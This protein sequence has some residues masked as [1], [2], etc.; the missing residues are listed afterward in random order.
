MLISKSKLGLHIVCNFGGQAP[1]RWS[2]LDSKDRKR[3]TLS[4][5]WALAYNDRPGE[6]DNGKWRVGTRVPPEQAGDATSIKI[7]TCDES[8]VAFY[9]GG[10]T[11]TRVPRNASTFPAM[12]LRQ[13]RMLLAGN[14]LGT[15]S[16][17]RH[18]GSP[19]DTAAGA[20]AGH[21]SMAVPPPPYR[22]CRDGAGQFGD[23]RRECRHQGPSPP[24]FRAI[25][26]HGCEHSPEAIDRP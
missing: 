8:Q 15:G 2:F 22:A 7:A 9:G 5:T 17:R 23:V 12:P 10:G 11:C 20:T 21:R 16:I 6:Y 14:W 1:F 18:L 24:P 4:R 25:V 3:N 19:H 26:G 13:T